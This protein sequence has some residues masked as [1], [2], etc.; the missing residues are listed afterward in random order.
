LNEVSYKTFIN[1]L[2]KVGERRGALQLVR[3]VDGKLV[4]NDVIM[5][6]AIIDKNKLVVFCLYSRTVAKNKHNVKYM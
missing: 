4:P 6:G 1:E 2:S 3:Q 5:F